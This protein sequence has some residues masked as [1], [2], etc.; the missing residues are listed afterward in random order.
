MICEWAKFHWQC[1]QESETIDQFVTV[2]HILT[3]YYTYGSLKEEMIRNHLVVGLHDG[4]LS[5]K[6]QMNPRL[7]LKTAISTASQGV[8]K[9]QP[10]VRHAEQLPNIDL[11]V[12]KKQHPNKAYWYGQLNPKI[13]RHVLDMRS[14]NHVSVKNV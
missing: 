14:F 6:L 3:K 1:Q 5:L 8:Q 10:I 13:P 2:Q 12:Y 9:Q 7:T 11:V 4:N